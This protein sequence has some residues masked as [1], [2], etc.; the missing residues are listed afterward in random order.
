VS[1]TLS[2][3]SGV[4]TGVTELY[5]GNNLKYLKL[6]SSGFEL[7]QMGSADGVL[8]ANGSN[9]LTKSS[10][11]STKLGYLTDVTSNLQA[12][13]DS[14]VTKSGDTMTGQLQISTVFNTGAPLLIDRD[15]PGY[16]G[17]GTGIQFNVKGTHMVTTYGGSEDSDNG[18]F[19][20]HL[21]NGGSVNQG[22]RTAGDIYMTSATL[23]VKP[24]IYL[25]NASITASRALYVDANKKIATSA[26]TSTELGYVSG[27]TSAIQTQINGKLST[28]GGTV[29][30]NL[31]VNSDLVLDTVGDATFYIKSNSFSS[32]S[33]ALQAHST[34]NLYFWR[35][36]SGSWSLKSEIQSDGRYNKISDARLKK[37]IQSLNTANSLAKVLNARCVHY[38]MTSD[39]DTDPRK[40]G[41]VAQETLEIN[42][43][44]VHAVNATLKEKRVEYTI[45][46]DRHG[47]EV[48]VAHEV[49]KDTHVE[50]LLMSYDDY[51]IHLIGA[52]QEQQKE[53][54]QLKQDNQSL[55]TQVQQ[56]ADRITQLENYVQEQQLAMQTIINNLL[57]I[58]Q[59]VGF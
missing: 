20:I 19:S 45:E 50:Q 12:Q 39:A 33:W 57:A 17:V 30:G 16:G 21:R 7:P 18:F 34:N 42:P 29:T 2:L 23:E 31:T 11:T 59:K 4:T 40:V 6:S 15:A 36:D 47:Q 52:A 37:D 14:K 49:E 46:V 13:V 28:S 43:Y 1:S 56:Q 32:S 38:L 35:Y 3:N 53:I 22:T 9:I 26:V 54:V 55:T 48:K 41:L 8:Y 51:I 25:N 24:T 27:V 10:I 44:A 5:G 58:Q